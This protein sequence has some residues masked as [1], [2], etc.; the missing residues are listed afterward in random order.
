MIKP[1]IVSCYE[2]GRPPSGA[3]S[4]LAWLKRAGFAAEGVDL[5]VDSVT[6]ERLSEADFIG[7]STPM[8]TAL[9]LGIRFA[10][11]ARKANPSV[12]ICF[13]GL[14]GHL[15]RE[16]LLEGD[17]D[18]TIG[19]EF[20]EALVALAEN[21]DKGGSGDVSGVSRKG[22][23]AEA[24]RKSLDHP[25]ADRAAF[26]ALSR[27]AKLDYGGKRI[28]GY[29]EA[30]RG[31][32]HV[33]AHCPVTPVYDG[34]FFVVPTETVIEDVRRQVEAG[35]E[36]I[37]FGDPDF[38]N[39]PAHARRVVEALNAEF[40]ELTF[41]FTAKIEH[42]IA[43]GNLLPFFSD[44]GCL[45]IVSA[46]ESLSAEVLKN[47]K[48]GHS[49]SDVERALAALKAAGIC[50]RPSLVSFT[51]WTTLDDFIEMLQ[52]TDE[53]GLSRNIDPVHF[54]I[55]LLVPPGSPL[56][57][58]P[59]MTPYLNGLQE[60]GLSL[61]WNHPDPAMDR[62]QIEVMAEVQRGQQSGEDA[63]KLLG[64]IRERALALKEGRAPSESPLS[65]SN[66]ADVSP[67]LTETWFCCAEPT[68][69]QL[70]GI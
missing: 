3:A 63:P 66:H 21:L 5:S 37:S 65:M 40:P 34:K 39:G 26:G 68:E 61:R 6:D 31:C 47:L 19:G 53:N 18:F 20:E 62:L 11:R 43:C 32:K 36:H 13:F 12:R 38:L 67:R 35:A 50:M 45:F 24:I 33:C 16:R 58:D 54:A 51:P 28:A 48:K 69:A 30:T 56:A 10:R 25:V 9:A 59:A 46:V 44:A 8:H 27:Y 57:T 2:L 70:S 49:R 55:R 23:E 4:P 42:L 14:Y 17:A 60:D 15:H 64:R 52:W 29:T 7:L 1:F 41:D 22:K